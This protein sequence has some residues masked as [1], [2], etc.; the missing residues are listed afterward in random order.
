MGRG[1]IF[2]NLYQSGKEST[3]KLKKEKLETEK[4]IRKLERNTGIT[5][6][7][8]K[9]VG[10]EIPVRNANE[11]LDGLT[12]ESLLQIIQINSYFK[13]YIVKL[14]AGEELSREDMSKMKIMEDEFYRLVDNI[15]AFW[16]PKN[17]TGAV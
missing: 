2:Y 11:I 16:Y 1:H 10:D 8:V 5:R 4:L 7:I 17:G 14:N 3:A 9:I 15:S 13:L 12:E 6:D